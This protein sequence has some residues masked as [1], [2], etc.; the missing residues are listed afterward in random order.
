MWFG[1]Y[2]RQECDDKS[3]TLIRGTFGSN[4]AAVVE[5][6]LAGD[7]QTHACAF[8]FVAGVQ[9]LKNVEDTIPDTSLRADA[10]VTQTVN[11]HNFFARGSPRLPG[12][13]RPKQFLPEFLPRAQHQGA[14]TWRGHC[15]SNFGTTGAFA[16]ALH[17]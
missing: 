17:Q 6:N 13:K 4:R 1:V 11:S 15:Q 8:V 14:G 10:I 3:S 12:A 2:S 7:G 9:T 16:M 5:G